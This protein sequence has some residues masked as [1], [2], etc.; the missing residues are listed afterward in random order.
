MRIL[1]LAEELG[2]AEE[3]L[4]AR[5]TFGL[6]QGAHGDPYAEIE[7]LDRALELARRANS[8][9][10]GRA[11]ANLGSILSTVG[12][13]DRA[14]QIHR[15]GVELARRL[16]SRLEYSLV[17]ECA[18]DDFIAGDWD[19]AGDRATSYLEHRGAGHS[20]IRV[21][22]LVLGA[23]ATARGDGATAEAHA[24]AMI[25]SARENPRAA[26]GNR[27]STRAGSRTAVR[28]PPLRGGSARRRSPAVPRTEAEI[29]GGAGGEMRV[30]LERNLEGPL[31]PLDR[32]FGSPLR[33]VRSPSVMRMLRISSLLPSS[34]VSSRIRR[35]SSNET[36][37]RREGARA[38]RTPG[39]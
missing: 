5:I 31:E 7:T 12:D 39:S 34:S 18:L 30:R 6:A 9:L 36:R 21:A 19:A 3:V 32:G 4:M 25:D 14:G 15:E 16:G 13:L 17:A 2:T 10:V 35:L 20:W 27:A 26:V 29:G 23:V 8:H 37:R 38:R 1:A 11:S 33:H 28:A 24:A 22:Y